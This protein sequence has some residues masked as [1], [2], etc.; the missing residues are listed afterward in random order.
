MIITVNDYWWEKVMGGIYKRCVLKSKVK[1]GYYFILYQW[2]KYHKSYIFQNGEII[3]I[4]YS[5]VMCKNYSF[6]SAT[7]MTTFKTTSYFDYQLSTKFEYNDINFN[8]IEKPNLANE[9][10]IVVS[11]YI[12]GWYW[13]LFKWYAINYKLFRKRSWKFW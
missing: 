10:I 6:I 3:I 11:K 1:L 8:N 12:V 7:S 9:K 2:I 5:D 13:L 4:T